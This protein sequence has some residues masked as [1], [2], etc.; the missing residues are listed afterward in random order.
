MY[1]TEIKKITAVWLDCI[2]FINNVEPLLHTSLATG[3][4]VQP[5]LTGARADIAL[6]LWGHRH[7]STLK[8][9]LSCKFT[10]GLLMSEKGFANFTNR[11][12]FGKILLPKC[13]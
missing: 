4:D 7:S 8:N 5:L 13:F 1:H 2:Y 12:Q 10:G 11:V 3:E 9:N 6:G